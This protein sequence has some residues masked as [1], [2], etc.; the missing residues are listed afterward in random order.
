M[1]EMAV[2]GIELPQPATPFQPAPEP[3]DLVFV[4]GFISNI[5]LYWD[6]PTF[7]PFLARLS[8]FSRLILFDKCGTGLFSRI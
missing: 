1:K 3:L 6:N 4:P 7:T 5:D 2:F 8:A